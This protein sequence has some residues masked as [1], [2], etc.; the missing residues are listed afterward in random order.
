[1][2]NRI[3]KLFKTKEDGILS[4]YFTAGYPNINDTTTIIKQL[5][6][7]G[8][9]LIEIGFPFSDPLADGPVIQQSSSRAIANGMTLNRLF[10]QL[11]EIRQHTQIP[12]VLM[13]YMNPILQFGEENFFK[14]C[15][16]TGIDGVILPDMPLD[17]FESN[18]KTLAEENNIANILL[19]TPETSEDRIIYIDHISR[20]FVYMVSSNSITGGGKKMDVQTEYFTRIK[21]MKL[22]NSTLIG[23][24]IRDNKTYKTA[25]QYSN[26]AIIGTAFIQH[27][28]EHGIENNSIQSFIKNIRP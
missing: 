7:A 9:E 6:A 24:G 26:G 16:E 3:E 14:L 11:K 27:I 18:L 4:I 25:C 2:I 23:F 17:Y 10:E 19:I 20:G 15:H 22:N 8:V 13:G 28:T 21:A 1:M 5:D 12:L